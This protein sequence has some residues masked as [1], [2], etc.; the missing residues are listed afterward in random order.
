MSS[1]DKKLIKLTVEIE[2][3]SRTVYV[4]NE[5]TRDTVQYIMS[6]NEPIIDQIADNVKDYL[7]EVFPGTL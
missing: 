3:N 6:T 5:E 7:Q 2:A 4:S 1:I